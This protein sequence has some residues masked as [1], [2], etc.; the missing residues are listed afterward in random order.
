MN[1]FGMGKS[2]VEKLANEKDKLELAILKK[3][4]VSKRIQVNNKYH[5]RESSDDYTERLKRIRHGGS[6]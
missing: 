1:L 5:T 6:N 3:S 2:T 4:Q